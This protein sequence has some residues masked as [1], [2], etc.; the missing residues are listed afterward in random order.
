MQQWAFKHIGFMDMSIAIPTYIAAKDKAISEGMSEVDA[1]AQGEKAV[2]MSQSAGGA[3]DLARIQSGGQ[4]GAEY[5]KLL[6][7][8]YSYFSSMYNLMRR[9]RNISS[10]DPISV[11]KVARNTMSFLYL[12]ALPAV[13][14]ELI[15][16]RGPDDDDDYLLAETEGEKKMEWMA[17]EIMAYPLMSVVGVRDVTNSV[18]R[19]YGYEI[20]PVAQG[21]E[22]IALAGMSGW[23]VWQGESEEADFKNMLMT[24]GYMFGLPS[25]QLWTV[26][27]N[28][29]A[30]A[31]DEE[32]NVPELLMLRE[33][34]ER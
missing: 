15:V 23:D 20:T 24:T 2:R 13:L 32:L 9:R 28:T 33:Q 31:D 18:V 16:G 10:R 1:I 21:I 14:S 27:D 19:G 6:T 3:K 26:I 8:F 11:N 22:S 34:R 5:R 12:V 30:L 17:K 29:M 25:R 4:S 7:M